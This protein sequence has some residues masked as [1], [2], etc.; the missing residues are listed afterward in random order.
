MPGTPR[1]RLC[2]AAGV[3]PGEGAEGR[4]SKPACA[5]LDGLKGKASGRSTQG[6]HTKWANLGES[7]ILQVFLLTVM[8]GNLAEKSLAFSAMP[9][10][11]RRATAL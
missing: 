8:V 1:N 10:A 7:F 6:G 11:T 4:G 5:G 9:T 3:A 2:R